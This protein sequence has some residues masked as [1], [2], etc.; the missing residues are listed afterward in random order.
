MGDQN[1]L[2]TK[3]VQRVFM[4]VFIMGLGKALS[5]RFSNPMKEGVSKCLLS[6][7]VPATLV[8]GMSGEKIQ[9]HHLVFI[10]GGI[11]LVLSRLCAG[12]VAS[13][14]AFGQ[15]THTN[16]AK[17]RRTALFQIS[18]MASALSVIPFLAELLGATE[19]G[20]GGMVDL[21]MKLY[22]LIVLPFVLPKF[23]EKSSGGAEM[24]ISKAL[25]G[26]INDPIT[27]AL[28]LGITCAFVTGG[29]G[30]K[31][32]PP[33]FGFLTTGINTLAA[34]QTPLLF[35]LIG[36]KL[37]FG[38]PT[39]LFCLVLLTAAHGVLLII[40]QLILWVFQPENWVE[41]FV[42]LFS[43]GAPSIVGYAALKKADDDGV[44]GYDIKFAFDIL[45][46]AFPISSLLQCTAAIVGES[47][48]NY[49]G[50]F[51]LGL[52][53]FAI[54]VKLATKAKFEELGSVPEATGDR[55][56]GVALANQ[57]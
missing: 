27:Q 3:E 25:F 47:Y 36:L 54:A 13:Y 50:F 8:K 21:S 19:A 52:I 42:I 28:I 48:G 23:G 45:G 43:Q 20:Y 10:G 6:F 4:Y 49:V 22:M 24:N 40:V 9:V 29:E 57:S 7:L 33:V 34:G 17:Y 16:V 5:G 51:G 37:E 56:R 38:G 1:I 26:L 14:L 53:A 30:L 44:P 41:T 32:L 12:T 2:Y 55:E 39:T 15:S 31:A 11:V 35:L 46:L 18:T